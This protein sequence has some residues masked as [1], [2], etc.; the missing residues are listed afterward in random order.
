MAELTLEELSYLAA[1]AKL[2][3]KL[4]LDTAKETVASFRDIWPR[5]RNNLTLS[6]EVW[7]RWTPI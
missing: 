3:E 1:K 5:E 7:A 2:P 6:K 4:V